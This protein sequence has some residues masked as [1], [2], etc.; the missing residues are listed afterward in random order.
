MYFH[1]IPRG[2]GYRKEPGHGY[3]HVDNWDDW[4]MF[5]TQFGLTVVDFAGKEH[6]IGP[7]KIGQ[8]QLRPGEKIGTGQRAPELP[9]VFEQLPDNLFSLGQMED[10]YESLAEQGELI[11]VATLT[12]LRDCA[13]DLEIFESNSGEAVMIK[14]L[15][16]DVS[17]NQV[18]HRFARLAYGNAILTAFNFQYRFPDVRDASGA[19]ISGASPVLSFAVTP[20]STPPT[21]V[22][23]LIGRNGV[24]KTTCMQSFA[25]A[26]L[27]SD[28]AE[29]VGEI[30]NIGANRD[31]WAFAGLVSISFSAFD[32]FLLPPPDR[33]TMRA[34]RVS[35]DSGKDIS[36]NEKTLAQRLTDAFFDSFNKC[37]SGTRRSR[38]S[39]A[40]AA[41]YSDPLFAEANMLSILELVDNDPENEIERKFSRLSSGHKIVLLTIT[42][43][44]ELVDEATIV[45]LDE[46][47]VHLHP[48]LLSAFIRA[49]ANLLHQRNGVALIATHSPVVL[50]EVPASCV[51]VLHRSGPNTRAER[52][53]LETFGENVG[54]LTREVFG[55]EVTDSGFYKLLITEVERGNRSFDEISAHFG[56][57]LGGEAR[58][59]LRALISARESTEL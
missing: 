25:A 7:V 56:H 34:H 31:E 20:L 51:W 44:V 40:V 26:A 9:E 49:L 36:A 28:I 58:A 33:R 30:E 54:T 8:K 38:W 19:V 1:V 17:E 29:A 39:S 32:D 18:R 45:L 57:Q 21:N 23:V 43:L 42:R 3:L 6:S 22:H 24:G 15:L 37:Q 13:Y 27:R 4:N 50:Q 46:P 2:V 48:P 12:A 10:Y 14:S 5:R 55:L 11:R 16:R 53:A 41:L 47:E 59:I 35:L 52:P